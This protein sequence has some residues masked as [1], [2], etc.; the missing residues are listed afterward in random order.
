[1]FGELAHEFIVKE[2]SADDASNFVRENNADAMRAYIAAGMRYHVA[3][4]DG[5]IVGFIA[6]REQKHLFHMFVD[7]AHH[8]QGIAAALWSVARQ[9]AIDAGSPGVFTVNASNYAVPV[10]QA[11]GFVPSAPMQCKNGLYYNPMQLDGGRHD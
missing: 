4:R 2:A 6:V 5:K 7:K 10:Y 9:A 8:R 1:M 11:M 3:E